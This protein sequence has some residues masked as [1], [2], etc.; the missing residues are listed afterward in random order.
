MAEAEGEVIEMTARKTICLLLLCALAFCAVEAPSAS[1]AQTAWSCESGTGSTGYVDAHCVNETKVAGQVKFIHKSITAGTETKIIFNNQETTNNT[2]QAN[3]AMLSTSVAGVAL[4][5]ICFEV[6]GSGGIKNVAGGT[7]TG[8]AVFEYQ[9]CV[10]PKPR[11]EGKTLCK[12]KTP[13]KFAETTFKNYEE[14]ELMGLEFTPGGKFFAEI[15]LV[16]GE[17]ACPMKGTYKL[18][19]K[20]RSKYSGA[21]GG[22]STWLFET[23]SGQLTFGGNAATFCNS[24]TVKMEG[25]STGVALTTGE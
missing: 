16:E 17:G 20:L 4:E 24:V 25:A 12:V 14:L 2:Q 15:T 13:I 1:A 7:I 18:E 23:L 22:S 9:E 6:S 5:I 8:N 10:M 21:T 3:P 11:N 19:G